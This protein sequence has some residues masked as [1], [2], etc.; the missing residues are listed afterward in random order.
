MQACVTKII[1]KQKEIIIVQKGVTPNEI[2]MN[3]H[4]TGKS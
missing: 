2:K 3:N 4:Q 1:I